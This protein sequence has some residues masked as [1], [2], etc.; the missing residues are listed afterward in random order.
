M[1]FEIV[2]IE[3]VKG[4]KLVHMNIRSL[5][6]HFDELKYLLLTGDIDI[7]VLGETWLHSRVPDSLINVDNYNLYRL[8]RQVTLPSGN[9]KRGGGLCVY[10]K[11]SFCVT[12]WPSLVVSNRDLELL[13]LSCKLRNSC[14]FNIHAAYTPPTG[15]VQSA[16]DLLIRNLEEVRIKSSGDN[17]I[18]GDMNVDLLKSD[19]HANSFLQ[20]VSKCSLEQLITCPTRYNR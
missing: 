13:S 10:V 18:L 11:N 2:D 6:P 3:S 19:R 20:L 5:L 17:V 1:T 14:R 12:E 16:V 8:E 7:L 9:V 4:I 15:T